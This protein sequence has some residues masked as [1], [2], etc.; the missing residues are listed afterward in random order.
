MA[1]WIIPAICNRCLPATCCVSDLTCFY[2]VYFAIVVYMQSRI[3]DT[4]G[5]P[6]VIPSSAQP[7]VL[8]IMDPEMR[9]KRFSISH[10]SPDSGPGTPNRSLILPQRQLTLPVQSQS[11]TLTNNPSPYRGPTPRRTLTHSIPAPPS[12]SCNFNQFHTVVE[13]TSRRCGFATSGT[14]FVGDVAAQE[15]YIF[16]R[17]GEFPNYRESR[18]TIST[19]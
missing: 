17:S 9:E 12:H 18:S 3:P 15:K 10:G 13:S 8:P 1:C 14:T 7:L 4:V 19:P 11:V 5:S 2:F 16:I 6:K